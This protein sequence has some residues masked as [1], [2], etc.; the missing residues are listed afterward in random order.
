MKVWFFKKSHPSIVNTFNS[1]TTIKNNFPNQSL[2]LLFCFLMGSNIL[3]YSFPCLWLACC[4]IYIDFERHEEKSFLWRLRRQTKF[5]IILCDHKADTYISVCILTILFLRIRK[6][7]TSPHAQ[8]KIDATS[9]YL[10]V[11][12]KS[13]AIPI[14]NWFLVKLQ[15]P[16]LFLLHYS[17]HH[18]SYLHSYGRYNYGVNETFTLSL[19]YFTYYHPIALY[20]WFTEDSI[21]S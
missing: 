18:L 2:V 4:T 17:T 5:L 9:N 12:I 19:R 21:H 11:T 6:K 10:R 16:S 1:L 15:L 3:G 20:L 13:N 14:S 7:E 8:K